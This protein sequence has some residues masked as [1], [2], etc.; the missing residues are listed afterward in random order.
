MPKTP[1]SKT[2]I[3]RLGDR[4]KGGSH[5]EADLQLREEY[6]DSFGEAYKVVIQKLGELGMT[7]T[8][9]VAAVEAKTVIVLIE[10][11]RRKGEIVTFGRYDEDRRRQASDDRLQIELELNRQGIL[12]EVVLLEAESEEALHR[13]HERYFGNLR[14]ILEDFQKAMELRTND[15]HPSAAD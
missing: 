14:E 2:Q 10:Y 12:H 15:R 13:T 3:D 6:R 11:D 9:R 5:S 1:A 7:P 8:G 4:L